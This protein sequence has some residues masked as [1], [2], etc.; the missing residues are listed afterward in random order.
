MSEFIEPSSSSIHISAPTMTDDLTTAPGDLPIS[1]VVSRNTSQRTQFRHDNIIVPSSVGTDQTAEIWAV[2]GEQMPLDHATLFY[3]IDGS[4]PDTHALAIPCE[5]IRTSWNVEAGYLTHWRALVPAQSAHIVVRYRLG[6]WR[7]DKF[8]SAS[9]DPDVWAQ[10]GQGFGF[11]FSGSRMITTFA[12][13]VED[14][15]PARP[16]WA[17]EAII[18]QIFLDRFSGNV[19]NS[20]PKTWR[21][22]AYGQYIHGGTLRGVSDTLPYLHSLGVTCL[23]LSPIHPAETYHRYDSLDFYA[24]DPLLGTNEDLRNLVDQAHSLGI[25]V[26]LD[27]VPS[28][29]SWHHPAFIS[30]QQDR[31]APSFDWFIFDEWPDRYKCFLETVPSLV[32]LNAANEQVRAHIIGSAVQWLRD[33]GID[34]FRLDHVIGQGMDFW[35]AFRHATREVSSEVITIAEATDTPDSLARYHGK[36]DSMLDFPLASALR[37]TFALRNW[38]VQQ[39]DH[40]L[41]SYERFMTNAPVRASFL[42]NHD[43]NRFLF[44]ADNDS[45]RLKLAALCQFTLAGLPIVY[46]GT[47]IGMTQSKSIFDLAG[48]GDDLAR[49]DMIWDQNLWN[50]TLLTFYRS[51][52]RL[53][54]QIPMLS[55]GQRHTIHVDQAHNTYAYVRTNTTRTTL[56]T[57]DVLVVFNLSN[58]SQTIPLIEAIPATALHLLLDTSEKSTIEQTH[59][60]YVIAMIPYSG[61]IFHLQA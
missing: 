35:T 19:S 25:R 40:F 32:S 1:E 48:G 60:G 55:R 49:Q 51:L 28:H 16:T 59:N 53:R 45:T 13:R 9:K 38:D 26:L 22:D 10:D 54:K 43:M 37:H 4:L 24:V 14:T 6:G 41:F 46:Y 50:D 52:I 18:Y 56:L 39:L 21:E 5:C 42:D 8:N 7:A 36:V 58:Q 33:Y 11:H 27:F 20:S 34:G 15:T 3:T 61:A 23:W 57:G 29:F 12:Y 44:L 31:N 2:S 47:E 17:Q 30:A